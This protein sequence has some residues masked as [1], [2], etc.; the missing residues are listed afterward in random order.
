MELPGLKNIG[1]TCYLNS[2]LQAIL[3]I[4]PLSKHLISLSKELYQK[5]EEKESKKIK[6]ILYLIKTFELIHSKDYEVLNP[7]S[8]ALEFWKVFPRFG[9]YSQQDSCEFLRC[10][11]DV[12]HEE[13]KQTT[14]VDK[15]IDSIWRDNI[16][17]D[18]ENDIKKKKLTLSKDEILELVEKRMPKVYKSII[19]DLFQG[20][21]LN[22]IG[23]SKCSNISKS[24]DP[25]FELSI[26]IPITTDTCYYYLSSIVELSTLGLISLNCKVHLL[27]C[28]SFFF[29]K[30][31]LEHPYYCSHCKS[32]QK[33]TKTFSIYRYP[34]ILMIHLKRFNYSS[35]FGSKLN[36]HVEFKEELKLGEYIYQLKS[37][38]NHHGSSLSSGHYTCYSKH[39]DQ[40]FDCNDS[41]T[42]K[43][44]IDDVL[45][46]QAYVLFY[47]KLEK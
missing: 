26:S 16:N 27:E 21:L 24:I 44:E 47:E 23:C 28:L 2:G 40:W 34:N 29:K 7:S 18:I 19:T 11:F 3:C 36:N 43:V 10:L 39:Q 33:A 17:Q 15:D 41:T 14:E 4:D 25:F 22:Q 38:I 31:T 20:Y 12:I 46:S 9:G 8:L 35:L 5:L 30:E 37:V 42:T 6:L 32:Y 13:T 1:N 45:S